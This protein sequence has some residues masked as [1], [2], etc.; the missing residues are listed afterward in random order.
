MYIYPTGNLAIDA[1]AIV[2]YN[3]WIRIEEL[4]SQGHFW[5]KLL[6]ALLRYRGPSLKAGLWICATEGKTAQWIK[7]KGTCKWHWIIMFYYLWLFVERIVTLVLKVVT[8]CSIGWQTT[9]PFSGLLRTVIV[10]RNG[11]DTPL[12]GSKNRVPQGATRAATIFRVFFLFLDR[13]LLF[14]FF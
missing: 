6:W 8:G 5:C 9:T 2:R 3:A 10:P 14:W 4:K 7:I 13:S 11:N 12:S 1:V